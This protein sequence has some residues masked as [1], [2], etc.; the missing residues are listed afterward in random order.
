MQ[1]KGCGVDLVEISR[2]ARALKKPT[3]KGKI[4]TTYEQQV[5]EGRSFSSWAARFAA[6][7]AV[8][9][10]LGRGF[11]QGVSFTEIEIRSNKW[12]QPRII[13]SGK[14]Q[15]IAIKQGITEFTVSLSHTKDLA[16]A[17]VIALGGTINAGCNN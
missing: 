14:T 17:Y 4:Y 7:E 12:G 16:I 5:L 6:K 13:L 2:I 9:K 10:A 1:V 3:F 8:M 11:G 15:Q